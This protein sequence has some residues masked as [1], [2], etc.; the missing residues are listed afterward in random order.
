MGTA[1]NRDVD[2]VVRETRRR[3]GLDNARLSD[4]FIPAHRAVALID[5]VFSHQHHYYKQVVP[6]TERHCWRFG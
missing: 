1:G 6:I 4:E 5:V 2:R 3:K